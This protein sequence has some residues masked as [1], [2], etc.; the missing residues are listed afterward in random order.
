MKMEGVQAR[1]AEIVEDKDTAEA[2]KP[3]CR[4][5]CKRPCFHDEYLPTF[6]RANVTLV[7]LERSRCRS[8]HRKRY[9]LRWPRISCGL[10]RVRDGLRG[11]YG[12]FSA[13]GLPDQRR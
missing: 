8:D 11:G 1:A 2:L 3:Y 7:R 12:L 4:Q 13:C 6:N 10:H 5:F 9:R